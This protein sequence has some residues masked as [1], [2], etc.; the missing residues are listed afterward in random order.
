MSTPINHHPPLVFLRV[1][2]VLG[3]PQPWHV[4]SRC[5][6][7]KAITRRFHS[8]L[9]T[10]K[11]TIRCCFRLRL[12][13]SIYWPAS[14]TNIATPSCPRS[15]TRCS[16]VQFTY[17]YLP[18][19]DPH[20]PR[21]CAEAGSAAKIWALLDCSAE[22]RII[23]RYLTFFFRFDHSPHPTTQVKLARLSGSFHAF[24]G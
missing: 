24:L 20:K 1:I 12:M 7:F 10:A 22:L 4:N 13:C 14:I 16:R 3:L 18:G 21:C 15:H 9:G 5:L 2:R 23:S 17:P 11:N 8:S 6:K 19:S